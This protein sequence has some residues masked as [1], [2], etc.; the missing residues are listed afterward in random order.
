V[1]S[2]SVAD[3]PAADR[4]QGPEKE[5][6]LKMGFRIPG[7]AGLACLVVAVAAA[8]REVAAQD[9][10]PIDSMT[11]RIYGGQ[12]FRLG[13]LTP[14]RRGGVPFSLLQSESSA[15]GPRSAAE[16]FRLLGAPVPASASSSGSSGGFLS[17]LADA[18]IPV[19]GITRDQLRDSFGAARRGHRHAGIDILAPKGTP[20]VAAV[21]GAVLK[22]KWDRGGGRTLR[23]V[24]ETRKYVF[25]YAHLS[26]YARGIHEGDPVRKG[27]VVGYVGR[28]GDAR[29]AHLHLGI[30]SLSGAPD[31]WWQARPLN[32]YTLLRHALGL[33]EC[34]SA[35][36]RRACAPDAAGT[37]SS[38]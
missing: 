12:P 24:D 31:H 10:T 16:R 25:Y 8:P 18:L 38:R 21:D 13:E 2:R 33:E 37:D 28:T 32:P 35:G 3:P 30:A 14:W 6:E 11:A 7:A 1:R 23:L 17:A 15:A 34:D 5:S 26:G 36:V 4:S 19:L 9:L 20:V 22:M 29:G 27:E